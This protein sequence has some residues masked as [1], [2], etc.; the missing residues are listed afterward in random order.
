M[1]TLRPLLF[2]PA[3]AALCLASAFGAER[4]IVGQKFPPVTFQDTEGHTVDPHAYE[5]SV[6]VMIS[7]IPW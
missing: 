5:G 3:A 6:L 2:T 4:S 7:G 1:R